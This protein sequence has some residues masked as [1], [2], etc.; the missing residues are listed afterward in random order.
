VGLLFKGDKKFSY[1][2]D[3]RTIMTKLGFSFVDWLEIMD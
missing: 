1:A 2:L 3:I